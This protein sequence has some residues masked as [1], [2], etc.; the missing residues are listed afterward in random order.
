MAAS[1]QTIFRGRL[2]VSVRLCRPDG[3]VVGDV[4]FGRHVP[5]GLVD[6]HHRMSAGVDSGADLNEMRLHGVRVTPGHDKACAFPLRGTDCAEDVGPLGPLI[7]WRPGA[8]PTSRPAAG[9][10]VL[11]ADAGFILEPQLYLG[12]G[13]EARPDLRQLGGEVFLNAS[14]TSSF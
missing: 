2:E 1:N 9:E 3:N 6:D 5:S 4:Q 10:L 13:R 11:L 8:G 7:A 14:T 12:T